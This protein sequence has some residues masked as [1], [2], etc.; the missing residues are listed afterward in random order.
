MNE[1]EMSFPNGTINR[2]V[3]RA[4]KTYTGLQRNENPYLVDYIL[5]K[6]KDSTIAKAP[7]PRFKEW[8]L[9]IHG[10]EFTLPINV[11]PLPG[12]IAFGP[13]NY[14]RE[15]I[16]MV[17]CIPADLLH[18]KYNV[19]AIPGDVYQPATDWWLLITAPRVSDLVDPLILNAC[20]ESLR[21]MASPDRITCFHVIDLYRGKVKFEWWLELIIAVLSNFS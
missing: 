15:P 12:N 21:T 10:L 3:I 7:C 9:D 20:L 13:F 16:Q 2:L 14:E 8:T 5:S 18:D 4:E 1:K 6:M 11:P 19:I 17:R